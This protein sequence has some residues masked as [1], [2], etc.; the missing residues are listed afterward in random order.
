MTKKLIAYIAVE[1]RDKDAQLIHF[2]KK[3]ANSLVRGFLDAIYPNITSNTLPNCKDTSGASFTMP[4]QA[5]N[6]YVASAAGD[7][8]NGIQIGT[9]SAAVTIVDYKLGS[10]ITNGSGSGQCNY[11]AVQ[12]TTPATT[13]S[14]HS[15]TISRGFTNLSGATINVTEVGLITWGG[16]AGRIMIDRTLM[17][18]SIINGA[19]ATIT[20]TMQVSV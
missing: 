2:E 10:Q 12:T 11:G 16:A 20:Y 1:I 15:L 19:T 7:P 6:I 13:G 3:E 17:A 14:T 18:F 4:Y 9:G 5:S 8:T